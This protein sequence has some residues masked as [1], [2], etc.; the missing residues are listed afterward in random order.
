MAALSLAGCASVRGPVN[1]T[2]GPYQYLAVTSG[3]NCE[4]YSIRA[5]EPFALRYDF[6][7]DYDVDT[8]ITTRIRVTVHNDGAGPVD[9]TGAC[10]RIASSNVPYQYNRKLVPLNAGSI[11]AG[12]KRVFTFEG[13]AV[14]GPGNPWNAM[15]GERLDVT[16]QGIKIGVQNVREQTVCFVPQNPFL[17]K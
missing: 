8:T 1:A 16:L 13:R 6:E 4:R 9:L 15:A 7:A 12:G 3:C 17:G 5:E 11:A 14:P 10:V 2:P